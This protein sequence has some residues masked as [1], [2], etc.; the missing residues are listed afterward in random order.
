MWNKTTDIFPE[1][2]VIVNTK[3]ED[4]AGERNTQKLIYSR[5]LW[6]HIDMSMYVYYTPTH[7][8]N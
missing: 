2:G 4:K 5:N 3:V 7:W 1:E 8:K 6:W